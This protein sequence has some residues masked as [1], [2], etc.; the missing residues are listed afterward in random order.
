MKQFKKLRDSAKS[1]AAAQ[2]EGLAGK[3]RQLENVL[4]DIKSRD[5]IQSPK[6]QELMAKVTVK[7][8][9]N[10]SILNRKSKTPK[11]KKSEIKNL[12]GAKDKSFRGRLKT[13][14]SQINPEI[15]RNL[16]QTI[17][18]KAE[19]IRLSYWNSKSIKAA[20][21]KSATDRAAKKS[22]ASKKSATKGTKN[23]GVARRSA[24]SAGAGKKA[25][26]RS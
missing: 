7:G 22:V 1:R 3:A 9:N 6:I 19:E 24:K 18:N 12:K 17:M 15:A 10:V 2:L 13:L 14:E 16:V 23:S 25:K 20:S 11:D 8:L 26:A 21:K 4:N 5:F